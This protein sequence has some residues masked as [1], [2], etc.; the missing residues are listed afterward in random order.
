MGEWG[1]RS[2]LTVVPA[3]WQTL[4]PCPAGRAALFSSLSR[5]RCTPPRALQE[6]LGVLFTPVPEL[7]A[8]Q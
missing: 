4:P 3:P 2:S 7:W 5:V 8:R 6:V 1:R